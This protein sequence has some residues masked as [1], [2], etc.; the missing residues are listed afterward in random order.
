MPPDTSNRRFADADI[1]GFWFTFPVT[2]RLFEFVTATVDGRVQVLV[3]TLLP[4]DGTPHAEASDCQ[5]KRNVRATKRNFD[6]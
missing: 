3:I 2:T 6:W 1:V 5:I 4:L